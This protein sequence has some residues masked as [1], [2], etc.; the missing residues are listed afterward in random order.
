MRKY[1]QLTTIIPILTFAAL[2]RVFG[3]TQSFW[4]D[5][6]IQAT[7]S[8]LPLTAIQWSADFQPPL[9][10]SFT[11]LWMKLG[12]HTEW[13]LRIPSVFFGVASVYYIYIFGKKLFNSHIALF[14]AF[15]LA[16]SPYHVHYSQE[17]RMYSLFTFLV[18]LSWF[19]LWEKK[20]THYTICIALIAFTHY[21]GFLLLLSQLVYILLE[22]HDIQKGIKSIGIAML[23]FVLWL[24]TFF[25]Q[26]NTAKLSYVSLPQWQTVL[27]VPFWKFPA[28]I[29]AKFAVGVASPENV[30]LYAA[31]VAVFALIML[32]SLICIYK[33]ICD[34][35]LKA[36][37]SKYLLLISFTFIPAITAWLASPFITANAPHRFVF[38]L[39]GLYILLSAGL[40]TLE[41]RLSYA[42]LA[43]LVLLNCTFTL[44]QLSNTNYHRENWKDAVAYTDKAAEK[45]VVLSLYTE[46]WP[47]ILWYTKNRAH[48]FGASESLP[49]GKSSVE[50]RL[51]E[52]TAAKTTPIIVYT[53]LF[54]IMDPAKTVES[55][56]FERGYFLSQEKDFRGVGIVQ[57]FTPAR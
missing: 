29:L 24:P 39:P 32:L 25:Q 9:F 41:K 1:W 44:L 27:G 21:F 56:L 57:T 7:L 46:S 42:L 38:L 31:A 28:L 33:K 8:Q 13:F 47:A 53:Y 45:G 35:N 20:W 6:A 26:L 12:V 51:A 2:L 18:L 43:I 3:T 17:F 10:Y 5:E 14:S 49:V 34:P 30:I 22:G 52:K 50:K 54:E 37:H 48:Y 55:F 15:L 40:S 4:H 36:L 19:F 16:V 23:P 11:H